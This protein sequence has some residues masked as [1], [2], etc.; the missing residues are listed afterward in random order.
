MYDFYFKLKKKQLYTDEQ[1]Y[2]KR[3]IIFALKGIIS[4]RLVPGQ[5]FFISENTN[6]NQNNYLLFLFILFYFLFL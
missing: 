1:I 5:S 3:L 2:V 4:C 6:E